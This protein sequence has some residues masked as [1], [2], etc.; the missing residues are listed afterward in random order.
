MEN[1]VRVRLK[2]QQEEVFISGVDLRLQ[3][4][5]RSFRQVALSRQETLRIRRF[6]KEGRSYWLIGETAP[7]RSR[8]ISDEFVVI[9]GQNL[10]A[11]AQEL[12]KKI[13]L[14]PSG[15]RK[16]DVVGLLPLEEYVV[17]VLASEMPLN[18]PMET[19][20]AQAV[21]ARSYALAVIKERKNK[22]YHLESSV[23]DQVFRHVLLEDENDTLTR[24]A[25]LAVKATRGVT[26]Q[27]N[28]GRVLKAF[29][30]SDCG[31]HT[32]SAKDVWKY[33]VNSGEAVDDSCPTN[34]KASWEM[35][36]GKEDLYA[37]LKKY[38]NL[39]KSPL[40]ISAL[41]FLPIPGDERIKDVRVAFNDG[42]N[43]LINANDFRS[44]MG[45]QDLR[46]TLFH[47]TETGQEMTFKGRGFGHGVGLCQ[48]GSRI[49]GQQGKKY[50]EI[51]MH[52]YPLA[53]LGTEIRN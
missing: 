10:H 6:Q 21:A 45:F 13:L 24:K 5:N 23:L 20:K 51:L 39:Q 7:S 36:I 50:Q 12:P 15:F 16:I 8:V 44:L 27:T 33:G 30:H 41:D 37:R 48:W 49:L 4:Q 46:S 43:R 1:E 47:V 9:E 32:V 17:G 35:K 38:L 25:A 29:Y 52:Y 28:Q 3:G 40:R 34:P 2:A 18:W 14:S 11:N 42:E 53:K 31:G 22:A 19:L 26:L